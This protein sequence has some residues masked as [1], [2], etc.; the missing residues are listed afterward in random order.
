MSI[1]GKGKY[2]GKKRIEL[3]A[4][5]N[6]PTNAEIV[7]TVEEIAT[8]DYILPAKTVS[9]NE[10]EHFLL[11]IAKLA[12]PADRTDYSEKYHELLGDIVE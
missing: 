1:K 6:L 4:E 3:D 10:E 5:L 8:S 2:D 12:R 9:T 11:Q 7:F